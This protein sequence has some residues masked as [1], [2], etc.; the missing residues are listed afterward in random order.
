MI[1]CWF[2]IVLS[3]KQCSGRVS[4]INSNIKHADND[5]LTAK[6]NLAYIGILV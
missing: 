2:S 6:L 1:V 4:L 5:Y 3:A